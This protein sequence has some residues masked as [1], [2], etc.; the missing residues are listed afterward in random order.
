[1]PPRR[2]VSLVDITIVSAEEA[3]TFAR[4][5]A[6]TIEK[7]GREA[8]PLPSELVALGEGLET[9]QYVP[10]VM[11][12]PKV[13]GNTAEAKSHNNKIVTQVNAWNTA[14][15]REGRSLL[16]VLRSNKNDQGETFYQV[17]MGNDPEEIATRA[18]R[19]AER[20]EGGRKTEEET[21]E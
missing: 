21:E 11:A 6:P 8:K 4:E 3:V 1:M 7:A 12:Y 19:I 15:S 5:G 18:A 9:G 16:F 17:W 10:V 20:A 13:E 2:E 14:S